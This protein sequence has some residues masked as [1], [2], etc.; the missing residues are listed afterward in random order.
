MHACIGRDGRFMPERTAD[1]LEP[2]EADFIALQEV[3]DRQVGGVAVADF[4]GQRLGMHVYRGVTMNREGTAFGNVLLSRRPAGAIRLH[5]ISVADAEPRGVIEA[6]FSLAGAHARLLATH[7]GLTARE[8]ALQLS[9]LLPL[10]TAG[11]ADVRVLAGDLNEWRPGTFAMRRLRRV[12]GRAPRPRSF[13]AHAPLL[14]LD[15]IHVLPRNA[16]VRVIAVRS[17]LTRMASD[18][19]PLLG[20]ISTAVE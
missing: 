11:D 19:L 9:D 10:V 20:E 18:H 16:L 5:D 4:L 17:P 1:V 7:L 12:F 3:E 15:S 2:L 8:R 13:P 6:N 14:A